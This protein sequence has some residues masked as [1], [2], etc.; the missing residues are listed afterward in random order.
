MRKHKA[1]YFI[2]LVTLTLMA[3]GLI[4]IFA[5]GPQ[6]ANFLNSALGVEKYSDNYFFIHQLISVGLSIVAFFIATKLPV[7]FLHKYAK[8]IMLAALI[9]NAAL[10]G[11]ALM[12]SSL[13]I[14]QLG[15]C[16]WIGTAGFSF[17]RQNF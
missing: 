13:A 4:V 11:L 3:V 8:W 9:L 7:K 1:D 17:S 2:G 10:A 6:R 12:K 5:I 16:R 14:C 15:G